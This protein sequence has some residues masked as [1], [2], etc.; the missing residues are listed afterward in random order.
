MDDY[1]GS[2]DPHFHLGL[3]SRKA[4]ATVGREY[5]LFGHLIDR[6]GLPQVLARFGAEAM[7]QVA[8]E[9]WMGASPVYTRRMQRSFRFEGDDVGTIMKGLQLDVGFPH[10]YMDVGYRLED[11]RRGTFWLNSCGALIDVEPMGE[12]MVISMCHHIEDPTFDATAVATNPRARVRPIHRP[13]RVPADRLPHCQ[14]E[15]TIDPALEPVR[16]IALT[17][18]VRSSRLARLPLAAGSEAASPGDGLP[19]YAGDFDPDFQLEDL[20]HGALVRACREFLVEVHL[21]IR[22]LMTTVADRGGQDVAREIATAQWIGSG[23]VGAARLRQAMRIAGDDAAA[24]VK[25]LQLHPAFPPREYAHT[26][27][28]VLDD[29]R[30]RFWIADCDAL[31]EEEPYGWLPLL[32]PGPHPALDAM[33]EAVNPRAR[34]LPTTPPTGARQAWEVVVDPAATPAAERPEVA[35]TRLSGAAAFRFVPRRALA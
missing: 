11:A 13:P 17:G 10:Q 22:S 1:A 21:L 9:E 27:F 34:C 18:R 20:S 15:I 12:K 30:G 24:I 35:L 26:G 8:I 28:D 2:F 32:G 3:L 33:V 5:M 16:E 4:L 25:V 31:A 6:A 29:R 7:Q 23:H 19:D 14:W